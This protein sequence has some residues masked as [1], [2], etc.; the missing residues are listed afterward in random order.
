MT[1]SAAPRQPQA[2]AIWREAQDTRTRSTLGGIYYLLAWLLTWLFSTS[3]MTQ[4]GLGLGIAALFTTL[5]V[6]R[7][8]HHLPSEQSP[9]AMQRW[10]NQQWGLILLTA[11][12]WGLIHALVLSQPLLSSA[13]TIATL[14]TVAFGTAMG[15][16]FAM[17]RGRAILALLLIYLPG[18]LVMA[19]AGGEQSATLIT[20][21]AYLSYLLL[22][23]NRSHREYRAT[24]A[25]ELKL[26]EQQESLEILSRTDSL[27]QLGNRH[28]FNSLFP[29]MV[30]NAQRQSDPLSLVLLDIDFFK[31]VNDLHGH[32]CGDACLSA[33]AE[34]MR[35]VF[36][37]DSDALL[38]LGGE[39]FGVLMPNTSLEQ[40]C[41]LAESFRQALIQ[42]GFDIADNR[43]PLTASL[44]VGCF[45]P[46][47]DSDA[48]T[49]F[50]RVDDA[51]YLAKG[52]GRNRLQLA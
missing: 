34:R 46:L 17:R 25:L 18:L 2:F 31:Q 40:A 35:Q 15:F 11:L 37:R 3:P 13:A 24:L 22:A 29:V 39:E 9:E 43:L 10:L 49:F 32:A 23:L 47:R 36:R 12:S 38:R 42:Q 19:L 33:F 8:L 45:D 44:G 21:A 14:S 50:K 52:M 1:D 26:L 30:A 51:L 28:Q 41:Q 16:N 27:T 4:L 5:L 7:L 6:L 20:L 48:A